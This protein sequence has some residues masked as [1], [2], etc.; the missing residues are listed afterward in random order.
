MFDYK[1]VMQDK[2]KVIYILALIIVF[3]ISL[4]ERNAFQCVT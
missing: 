4:F 3:G 1:C 2:T